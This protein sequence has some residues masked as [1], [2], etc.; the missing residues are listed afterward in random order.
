MKVTGKASFRSIDMQCLDCGYDEERLVDV[1]NL[2]D[3]EAEMALHEEIKCP[4]CDGNAFQRVWRKAPAGKI[5]ND[6]SP[7]NIEKMKQSF[8]QRYMKKE[9]DDVKHKWGDKI[10]NESLIAGEAR[11]IKQGLDEK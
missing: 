2:T 6:R 7:H 10:V 3:K 4:N 11:R 5:G 8:R 9:I 1:R